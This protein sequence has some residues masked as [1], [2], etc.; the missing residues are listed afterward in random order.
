LGNS[1][2]LDVVVED[3]EKVVVGNSSTLNGPPVSL[4]IKHGGISS[5]IQIVADTCLILKDPCFSNDD[6]EA[7]VEANC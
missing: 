2:Q 3:S 7:S 5:R 4:E 6:M 1:S